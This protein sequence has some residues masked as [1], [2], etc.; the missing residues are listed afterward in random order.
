MSGVGLFWLRDA[1]EA[2]G[3]AFVTEVKMSSG[4]EIFRMLREMQVT[5]EKQ[6]FEADERDNETREVVSKQGSELREG[7]SDMLKTELAVMQR[8]MHWSIGHALEE[9]R[10]S[11]RSVV[12]RLSKMC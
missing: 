1:A 3:G 7:V 9:P 11:L 10:H 8:E 5:F 12:R 4:D 6:K 2:R